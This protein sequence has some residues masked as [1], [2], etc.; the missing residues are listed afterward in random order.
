VST[1][2]TWQGVTQSRGYGWRYL[3]G[4]GYGQRDGRMVLAH[5]HAWEQANGPIPEAMSVH[6]TCGNRRCLNVEHMRLLS[7]RD[8]M[9]AG[10]HGKL[11]R[12]DAEEIRALRSAGHPG[13][14]VAALFGI[15]KQ[16]VCNVFKGR[17]WA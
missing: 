8:H 10:G 13:A 14:E 1:C 15:S 11:T 5:R 9:G 2:D 16:Q 7:Q 12:D 17:C 6:H 3:P 4:S